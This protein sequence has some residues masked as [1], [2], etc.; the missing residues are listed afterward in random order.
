MICKNCSA[1]YDDKLEVCPDC[2]AEAETMT[3]EDAEG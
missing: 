1:E 3:E 2:G